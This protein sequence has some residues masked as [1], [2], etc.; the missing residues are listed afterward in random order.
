MK[1]KPPKLSH[2]ILC[3][4][5]NRYDHESI[6]GDY[7]EVF[8]YYCEH[9]GAAKGKNWYRLQVLKSVPTFII[10]S[11]FRS[12]VMLKS[13]IVISLRNYFKFRTN[14]LINTL[15]LAIGLA[16]S[17][18][19]ILYAQ[20]QLSY[21][22][23]HKDNER[24]FRVVGNSINP[25]ITFFRA[26]TPNPLAPVMEREYQEVE[27]TGR[28][29]KLSNPFITHKSNSFYENK[30]F[31]ADQ[32]ILDIFS[33]QFVIGNKNNAFSEINSVI[34]TEET[35]RKYFGEDDPIGKLITHNNSTIMKV[36]AV[37]KSFPEN[38]HF[39]FD[40]IG[41]LKSVTTMEWPQYFDSWSSGTYS[42]LKLN[43]GISPETLEAKFPDFIEQYYRF[44][45]G[46]D[47]DYE[48]LLQ[49]LTDI[50]LNSQRDGEIEANG[51]ITTVYILGG[52]AFLILMIACINYMNLATS[53]I[54][55]RSKEL[56]MRKVIGARR[57]QLIYQFFG[58]S[59]FQA[60]A[61][62][63]LAILLLIMVLPV[64]N[65]LTSTN[66]SFDPSNNKD[67]LFYFTALVLFVGLISGSYPAF[68]LS[69]YSPVSILRN[70]MMKSRNGYLRKTLVLFQFS[71]SIVLL[72][73][74]F[75]IY[76]QL[77]YILSKDVGYEKDGIAV[78]DLRGMG[79]ADQYTTIKSNL[80]QIPTVAGATF[81]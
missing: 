57:S 75:I 64:F 68:L 21:D 25:Y 5:R 3:F 55:V 37:V 27:A 11:V 56:S 8:E 76:D 70:T 32:G 79:V 31:L 14:S 41:D 49:P 52:I 15:G 39:T 7:E 13:Y 45:L 9:Y 73:S 46:R 61:G 2:W 50:H 72:I 81:S 16:C 44:D 33:I 42:Y 59:V 6:I 1:I 35:A 19:I 26:K 30:F 77:Q 71:A 29:Y 17:M 12:I 78:F 48:F 20:N 67:L 34:L 22:N 43:E 60:I 10:N 51:N 18:L 65:D 66:I 58:E 80:L 69:S 54:S 40:F 24:I 4:F 23:F 62:F 28:L 63:F 74:S 38:S 53:N 47:E 36:T